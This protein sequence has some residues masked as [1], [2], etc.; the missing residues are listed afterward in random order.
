MPEIHFATRFMFRHI[1]IAVLILLTLFP[2]AGFAKRKSARTSITIL[3]LDESGAVIPGALLSVQPAKKAAA[4]RFRSGNMGQVSFELPFGS[5]DVEVIS[6]GFRTA[7]RHIE[8]GSVP[9]TLSVTLKV[10]SCPPGCIE[11]T[12]TDQP[13]K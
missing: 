7:K 6:P 2:S 11:V 1:T 10:A 5:Y 12:P 8:V 3:I 4:S 9:R 13:V